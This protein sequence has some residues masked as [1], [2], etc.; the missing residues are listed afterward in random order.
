MEQEFQREHISKQYEKELNDLRNRILS[1]SCD[2]MEMI[3][4]TM[5][6]LVERNSDLATQMIEYDRHIDRQE[7]EIDDLAL[8]II[9]LRQ[10]AAGD[11]R[12]ITLALK[13]STDLERIGDMC[14]NIAERT[15]ELNQEPQLKPYI[16]LPKM[17][18]ATVDM[19]RDS[20]EAFLHED[21][22]VAEDVLR[23]DDFV[24]QLNEQVFRELLTFMME[25]TKNIG[26]ATRL[27]FIS[28]YLERMAD[29]ATNI[30]EMVIF[31]VKGRDVRHS[32]IIEEP[33]D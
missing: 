13:I 6:S 27:M 22:K 14:V 7:V 23:R 29:H 31:L 9:A 16:D 12:F 24:D 15:I 30:A 26:R 5:R 21:A 4:Q 2:L 33:E 32:G 25:D 20:L 3:T 11:L 1:M 8:K 10:P 18:E 19:I 17:A 28:K